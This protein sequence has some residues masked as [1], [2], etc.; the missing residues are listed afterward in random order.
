MSPNQERV[1]RLPLSKWNIT[2][3][4]VFAALILAAVIRQVWPVATVLSIGLVV[5]I[6]LA[7]AA[8]ARPSGDFERVSALEFHDERDRFIAIR[9]L[10]VV[11]A[12]SLAL[13]FLALAGYAIVDYTAFANSALT[14][15]ALLYYLFLT[16]LWSASNWYFSRR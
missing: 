3:L 1:R 11:G 9:A 14:T 8:R 5:G 2:S 7:I 12:A 4:A 15:P 10:A 6:I 16:V 13:P